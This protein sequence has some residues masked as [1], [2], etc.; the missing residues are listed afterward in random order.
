[1]AQHRGADTTACYWRWDRRM[2]RATDHWHRSHH[3]RSRSPSE[4]I[5]AVAVWPMSVMALEF[6]T[7]CSTCGCNAPAIIGC[8]TAATEHEHE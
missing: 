1:M 2:V 5:V 8:C 7:I 3:H 4:E 6:G